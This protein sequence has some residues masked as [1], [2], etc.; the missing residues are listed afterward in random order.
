MDGGREERKSSEKG[1]KGD[2]RRVC[3]GGKRRTVDGLKEGKRE[4]DA[5]KKCM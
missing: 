1:R 5:R 4:M 3:R 2:R